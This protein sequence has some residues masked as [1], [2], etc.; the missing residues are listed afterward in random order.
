MTDI[1]LITMTCNGVLAAEGVFTLADQL[2]LRA[3]VIAGQ[4]DPYR[5][6]VRLIAVTGHPLQLSV[7]AQAMPS[8]TQL[9]AREREHDIEKLERAWTTT[10][11]FSRRRH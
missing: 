8:F 6:G 9:S 4:T 3:R 2:G 1:P 7:M 10:P 5:G 11:K